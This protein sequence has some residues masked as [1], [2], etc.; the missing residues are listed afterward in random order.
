M[1][2]RHAAEVQS[3]RTASPLP[4]EGDRDCFKAFAPRRKGL[5]EHI[6]RGAPVT[7]ASVASGVG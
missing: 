5:R 7:R 6:D 1:P 3:R 2:R 4:M